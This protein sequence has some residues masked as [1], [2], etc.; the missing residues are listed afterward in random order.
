MDDGRLFS[1]AALRF[2]FLTSRR[3]L[4]LS[5]STL[6]TSMPNFSIRRTHSFFIII[7][8]VEVTENVGNMKFPR[9]HQTLIMGD[10]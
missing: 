7:W 1:Y 5:Y 6:L 9:N 3:L 8:V 10:C 4:V 2:L